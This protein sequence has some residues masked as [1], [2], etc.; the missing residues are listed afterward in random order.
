MTEQ[1]RREITYDSVRKKFPAVTDVEEI[2]RL[3]MKAEQNRTSWICTGLLWAS[4]LCAVLYCFD[5]VTGALAG[6]CMVFFVVAAFEYFRTVLNSKKIKA[7]YPNDVRCS[8]K[9]TLTCHQIRKDCKLTDNEYSIIKAI[10]CDKD[11]RDDSRVSFIFHKYTLFFKKEESVSVLGFRAKRRIY[12][13]APLDVEYILV[14]T[15]DDDVKAVY[16][17]DAWAVSPELYQKCAFSVDL[18]NSNLQKDKE[19]PQK[20]AAKNNVAINILL[21]IAHILAWVLP[22]IITLLYLPFT[23]FFAT[24]SAVKNQNWLSVLNVVLGYVIILYTAMFLC[25]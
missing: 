20:L 10:L 21:L 7:H 13:E 14:V 15:P 1:K 23:T 18:H 17:A 6:A 22:I 2:N 4:I 24:K 5:F 3:A 11:D 12:L 8:V 16:I 25:L 9:G 19:V